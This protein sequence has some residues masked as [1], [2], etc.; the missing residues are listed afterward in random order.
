MKRWRL[1]KWG[2]WRR[3]KLPGPSG[4][5]RDEIVTGENEF[6]DTKNAFLFEGRNSAWTCDSLYCSFEC[7]VNL[8]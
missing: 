2:K 5:F 4:A 6:A 1:C 7:F 8:L 3:S